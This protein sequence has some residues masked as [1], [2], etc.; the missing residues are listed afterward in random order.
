MVEDEHSGSRAR[1]PR[2]SVEPLFTA[3]QGASPVERP[4]PPR[5]G[6]SHLGW[7]LLWAALVLLALLAIVLNQAF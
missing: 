3:L 6:R 1:S 4:N 2:A 5:S 7:K